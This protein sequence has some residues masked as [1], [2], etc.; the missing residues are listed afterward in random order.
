MKI[1]NVIK[2]LYYYDPNIFGY[3]HLGHISI[4]DLYNWVIKY[5]EVDNCE[6]IQLSSNSR[7]YI[8]VCIDII[9]E[10]VADYYHTVE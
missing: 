10:Y 5:V 3:Q 9:Q 6:D 8:D 2:A 7:K 4:E 1:E